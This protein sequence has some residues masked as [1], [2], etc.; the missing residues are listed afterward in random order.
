M[1]MQIK[2]DDKKI[3]HVVTDEGDAFIDYKVK[4]GVITGTKIIVKDKTALETGRMLFD[5]GRMTYID[6]DNL[7]RSLKQSVTQNY[8]KKVYSKLK[9]KAKL[10]D[11]EIRDLFKSILDKSETCLADI[12]EKKGTDPRFGGWADREIGYCSDYLIS[13]FRDWEGYDEDWKDSE[14][15]PEKPTGTEKCAGDGGGE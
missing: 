1:E 14:N 11:E 5:D 15:E 4:D 12:K 13:D 3:V 2:F 8:M 6:A 10:S 9:N 7:S